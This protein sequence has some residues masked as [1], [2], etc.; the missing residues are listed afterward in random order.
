[1][2][3]LLILAL[4]LCL[5]S[6]LF[7]Q[8]IPMVLG[9]YTRT[10][11]SKGLYI[12][13][14]D[15]QTG[16]T[17]LRTDMILSNPS[18]VAQRGHMLYTVN[19]NQVGAVSALQWNDKVLTLQNTLP[20]QG[21]H[22]CHIV[23]H[24]RLPLLVVSNYSSGSL[25]LYSLA[26]DGK[27][28]RQEDLIQFTGSGADTVRQKSPHVHSAFF[29][30]QGDRLYVSDLGTDRIIEYTIDQTGETYA[31]RQL[32]VIQ[33]L[34]GTG[35]R[36]LSIN[37][38]GDKIY[39]VEELTATLS[40]YENKN[41][42]W[43]RKQSLR[44]NPEGFVGKQGAAD[45]KITPDGKHLYATD[46]GDANVIAHYKIKKNGQ[47][48]KINVYSVLGRSPRNFNFSPDGKFLLIANQQSNE[49]VIYKRN[50]RTGALKDSKQRI[51][52][53]QPVCIVF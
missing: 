24:P 1:M 10:D 51:G 41:G 34:A 16:L 40:Y 22:P 7:A 47:L 49:V 3:Q 37:A 33:A 12:Y 30:V 28:K 8:T 17:T 53:S 31:F 36:H 20:S 4:G 39:S 15:A 44:I 32:S 18:F 27:L 52:V 35:P 42:Q 19:E 46:R 50:I 45:I 43:L 9:S 5:N 21:A 48:Q 38:A 11:N 13:D 6:T 14:F 29:N 26:A 2:K 25:V 23:L